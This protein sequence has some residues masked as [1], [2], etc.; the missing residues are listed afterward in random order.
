MLGSGISVAGLWALSRS[1]SVGL[2]LVG[3]SAIGADNRRSGSAGDPR[4]PESRPHPATAPNPKTTAAAWYRRGRVRM[5][6]WNIEAPGAVRPRLRITIWI[7]IDGWWRSRDW[8][9]R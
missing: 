7:K 2:W 8:R 3:R 1:G 5:K 9:R 4:D 6:A